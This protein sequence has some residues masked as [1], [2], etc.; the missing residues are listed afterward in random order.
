MALVALDRVCFEGRN[1]A[2]VSGA[3]LGRRPGP[4]ALDRNARS[5]APARQ[6]RGR[7]PAADH[8]DLPRGRSRRRGSRP[9]SEAPGRWRRPVRRD[10]RPARHGWARRPAR[11][12]TSTSRVQLARMLATR[13]SKATFP[14]GRPW[15]AV[16]TTL[17]S[18]RRTGRSG[19]GTGCPERC[20]RSVEKSVAR[21]GLR[22]AGTSRD[23]MQEE[24]S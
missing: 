15:H 21:E 5:P 11:R 4:P 14:P 8:G 3:G 1:G 10:D 2:V 17:P 19:T 24:L 12:W 16:D 6:H 7:A 20:I 23:A 22:P 13:A 9:R 18:C